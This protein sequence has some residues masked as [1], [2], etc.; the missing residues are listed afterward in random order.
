MSSPLIPPETPKRNQTYSK[1]AWSLASGGVQLAVTVLLGVFV[2]Y[3]LDRRWGTSP[4][5]LVSGAGIGLFLG[6]YVFLKPYFPKGD[7]R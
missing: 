7:P 6:L 1:D 5:L 2:G 4:W 3:R